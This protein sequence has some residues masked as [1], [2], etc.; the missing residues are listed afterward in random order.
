MGW[1][2]VQPH[3]SHIEA[4]KV[5]SSGY[6][7]SNFAFSQV[8]TAIEQPLQDEELLTLLKLF[9][10]LQEV[11]R[12][13]DNVFLMR[14]KPVNQNSDNTYGLTE[15]NWID[16]PSKQFQLDLDEETDLHQDAS[17]E[18]RVAVA[19][20]ELPFL[21]NCR[22]I[23]QLS[24]S[25]GLG[26]VYKKN[27]EEKDCSKK[28]CLRLW[29]ETDKAYS[30]AE[31]RHHLEPFSSV[32]DLSMY[33]PTRRHYIMRG[34]FPGTENLLKDKPHLKYYDGADLSLEEIPG[35]I[36]EISRK[37]IKEAYLK[38]DHPQKKTG[39]AWRTLYS[40][41]RNYVVKELDKLPAKELA[42]KRN[43]LLIELFRNE[44][45]F[46]SGD[47]ALLIDEVL[48]S[49]NL[50][51][52]R[53][54]KDIRYLAEWSG[55]R[56]LQ[57]LKQEAESFRNSHFS[58]IHNFHEIDLAKRDW[59]NLLDHR[60]VAIKSCMGTNKTKG[61]IYDQVRKAKAEDKSVL[62][63][64]PLIAVTE[65]IAKDVEINHYHSKGT[66]RLQKM[67]C[68]QD[69]KYLAVC[70]QSLEIYNDT[71]IIPQFDIVIIDEASQ[72]FR[73]W[74]D[75]THHIASM[76]ILF[77]ILD[78]SENAIILDADIDDEL[79]L[80][81][82]SRIANFAPETS[83]LY[84]N[85]ASYLRNYEIALEDNYGRML[86]KLANSIKSGQK[87]AIF[88]DWADE[89]YTISA[90]RLWLEK[91]T[92]KKGKAF[93][94]ETVRARAP[95][96]KSHPNKTI[97]D[98]MKNDELD[99][100]IVSPWC[101]CGWDYLEEGYDFDEVFVIST[102]QFFSAQKI[103]QMLRRMRMT[104]KASVYLSNR[105]KPAWKNQTF[106]AIEKHKGKSE[107]DL[108]RME[109][110]QVRAK[111][112]HEMDLA[113]V[114]WL[115]EELLIERGAIVEKVIFSEQQI[116]D[117][118]KTQNDWED[119]RKQ[120]EKEYADKNKTPREKALRVLNNFKRAAPHAWLDLNIEDISEAKMESLIKRDKKL[121]AEK[122]RRFSRL[123][124]ADEDER[125]MEDEHNI[126]QFNAV[127]G[128]LL[129]AFWFQMEP[130]VDSES[131]ISFAHWYADERSQPI[132]G[133]FEDVDLS[134][135]A[136]IA[137]A[138]YD[139][140]KNEF[141]GIGK[142]A[143]NE[144]NRILRPL[145][146][147]LDL[148]FTTKQDMD[149]LPKE[150]RIGAKAA[151]KNL[152]EHY[153]QT[154]EPGFNPKLKPTPQKAWLLKNIKNKQKQNKSLSNDEQMFML[155]RMTGF[156]ITRKELVA[157]VWLE[158]MIRARDGF[159]DQIG[160]SENHTKYCACVD[161]QES[162]IMESSL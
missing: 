148:S 111:Q 73:N 21:K 56:A 55:K 86:E 47:C 79:C 91:K 101:N 82:L 110:W 67:R 64:T 150:Q 11:E 74:A 124:V 37:K 39:K 10:L 161:C 12:D 76:D 2:I 30:C 40:T 75:I 70:Y 159:E 132:F 5:I 54:P 59:S 130:L 20:E 60:A 29:V 122:A 9:D 147:S 46:A 139:A 158:G 97:S 16:C 89:K 19:L 17:L 48:N 23:A 43:N 118:E 121:N 119:F 31:L 69:S 141:S 155:S 26:K 102:A 18:E 61:V 114:P 146:Q 133:E 106:K 162:K 140:I 78:R 107:A 100:L 145:V 160:I 35:E 115:L 117:A 32:I 105:R 93:D 103:K 95:E 129:D 123:I 151:E 94:S 120:A 112:S 24:S 15:S 142:D 62:I 152:L 157:T 87:T 84:L 25:A 137:R 8:N 83:A 90:F 50:M 85:S 27:G 3:P 38:P 49:P 77:N 4:R 34:H 128:K 134:G 96:L 33:E 45:L 113:N 116:E 68:L 58:S 125:A 53:T 109:A 92:G 138:N 36:K 108:E 6:D 153:K 131:F 98:W 22:F 127:L 126:L 52:D 149:K 135:F 42:R 1:T 143:W 63:I 13:E 156:V 65:Q 44:A 71:G 72:V 51:G 14:G 7:I 104:R 99:F 81:G 154:K 80:W 41:N 88:V 144:P 66:S 57:I 28:Y 136:R